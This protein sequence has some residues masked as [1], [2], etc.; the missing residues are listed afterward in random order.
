MFSITPAALTE[1]Q[2]A[3]LRS[4]GDGMALR[5]AAR[6]LAN[7]HVEFGMGLDNEREN[8]E[9]AQYEGLTVLLGARSRPYLARTMLDYVELEAGRFEFVFVPQSGGDDSAAAGRRE[10]PEEMP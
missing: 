8:D 4:D 3:V 6:E 7:G 2:A 10:R 9:T 5:I 1:L